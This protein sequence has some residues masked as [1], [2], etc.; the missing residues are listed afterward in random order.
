[1]SAD[2]DRAWDAYAEAEQK[3]LQSLVDQAPRDTLIA[4][5][6]E[7]RDT[8]TT[9]RETAFRDI[10]AAE[11]GD[12]DDAWSVAAGECDRAELLATLWERILA[13]YRGKAIR[14]EP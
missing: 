8:A 3:Y 5:A 14:A 7:A 12:D 4:A 11:Q 6:E 9:V 10:Q 2:R 1:M 13:A